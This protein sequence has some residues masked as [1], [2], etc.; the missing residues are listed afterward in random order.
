MPHIPKIS[1]RSDTLVSA[2]QS[3]I[4]SPTN[5][6]ASQSPH[7]TKYPSAQSPDLHPALQAS[8]RCPATANGA[9][10]PAL[11]STPP[12]SRDAL[13]YLLQACAHCS[14]RDRGVSA[15]QFGARS[16]PERR[17]PTHAAISSSSSSAPRWT[18]IAPCNRAP[19]C[20]GVGTAAR[21]QPGPH[22]RGM[23]AA[24]DGSGVGAPRGPTTASS[25]S[26]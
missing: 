19:C 12:K 7:S 14:S 5:I 2:T 10:C 4:A 3:S 22:T 8:P 11:L 18:P 6:A 16:M 21:T 13:L 9:A 15:A 1:L 20:S 17:R 25:S 24:I 23:R 26:S